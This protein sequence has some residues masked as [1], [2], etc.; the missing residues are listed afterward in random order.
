MDFKLLME[1]RHH[2]TIK[3]H[4]PGR[5]RIKFALALLADSRAQA[6]KKDAGDSPP[7]FIR[8]TSVNL[9]TRMVVIEYDPDVIVPEKLHEALTTEDPARFTELAAEFEQ[10][11]S[12]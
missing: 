8:N 9:F 2:L 11:V 4:V 5:I 7:P 12:A 1:L 3:H 10:I 6:L